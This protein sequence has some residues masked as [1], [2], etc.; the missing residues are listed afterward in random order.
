MDVET[1]EARRKL[2]LKIVQ[3]SGALETTRL[4]PKP[5]PY[6]PAEILHQIWR[7]VLCPHGGINLYIDHEWIPKLLKRGPVPTQTHFDSSP[8]SPMTDRS[9]KNDDSQSD[10]SDD[11]QGLDL[12]AD[13]GYHRALRAQ[14]CIEVAILRLNHSIYEECL[15]LL[16]GRN[17]ITFHTDA[18]TMTWWLRARSKRQ[19][20]LIW[21]LGFSKQCVTR[22]GIMQPIC[23]L[24]AHSMQVETVTMW[25]PRDEDPEAI[26]EEVEY[27]WQ[28]PNWCR[29]AMEL[30]VLLRDRKIAQLRLLFALD[31]YKS[32]NH[33]PFNFLY[34]SYEPVF[35]PQGIHLNGIGVVNKL[36]R[37]LD[38]RDVE[39]I[40]HASFENAHEGL[41]ASVYEV[42]SQR[43]DKYI[44]ALRS[45]NMRTFTVSREDC[46]GVDEGTVVVLRLSDSVDDDFVC[47]DRPKW[48][49]LHRKADINQGY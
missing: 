18:L 27:E 23:D 7:H 48:H 9:L 40:A 15:P 29:C 47:Q 31:D 41:A 12:S 24:I 4:H 49:G 37:T 22:G 25:L 36:N 21:H 2:L 33:Q 45:G 35:L 20:R 10:S 14:A 8:T 42:C 38:A 19:M 44:E 1:F 46:C 5:N 39:L 17:K 30:R 16:Y 43:F 28:V 34:P 26:Y 11:C 32:R 3:N 13:D 6:L